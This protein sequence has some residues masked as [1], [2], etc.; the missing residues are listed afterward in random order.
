MTSCL[1]L[2]SGGSGLRLFKSVV[3]GLLI[4]G[5]RTIVD[6][7]HLRWL[8]ELFFSSFCEVKI[9]SSQFCDCILMVYVA[10]LALLCFVELWKYLDASC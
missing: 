2:R 7:Y 10:V 1:G 4:F 8:E 5:R 9:H 3:A 6:L